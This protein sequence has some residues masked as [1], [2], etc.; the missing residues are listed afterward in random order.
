MSGLARAPAVAG[1]H[2]HPPPGRDPGHLRAHGVGTHRDGARALRSRPRARRARSASGDRQEPARSDPA[3]RL[4]GGLGYLSEDRKGEGLALPLSIADNVTLT[5][6]P[7]LR[8]PRRRSIPG[9]SGGRPRRGRDGCASGR[10][11][12][13]SRCGRSRAATSRRWRSLACSTRRP[14]SSCST[15]PRAASTSRSKAQIYD[16]IDGAGG[17]RDGRC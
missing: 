6:S 16:A 11:D 15:S 4:A 7:V 9:A 10:A 8:A 14:T 3:C 13:G 5:R 2:L 1:R 17:G 12:P